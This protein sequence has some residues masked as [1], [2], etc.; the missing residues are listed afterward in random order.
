[1]AFQLFVD[2]TA[3]SRSA[4]S[5]IM[6]G[7]GS[8]SDAIKERR[9]EKK[10]ETKLFKANVTQAAAMG[11]GI[12]ED[13]AE[14][15]T[16]LQENENPDSIKGLLAGTIAS[17][18]Q[19]QEKARTEAILAQAEATRKDTAYKGRTENL[20]FKGL[21]NQN[22]QL[23][24]NLRFSDKQYEALNLSNEQKIIL[25]KTLAQKEQN[26]LELQGEDIQTKREQR[27]AMKQDYKQSQELHG[28]N[29]KKAKAFVDNVKANIRL[30][31]KTID[32]S[33]KKLGIL[34][35][36]AQSA[37]TNSQTALLNAKVA[38]REQKRKAN[39]ANIDPGQLSP[40]HLSDGTL[41]PGIYLTQDKKVLQLDDPA[42][43]NPNLKE[44]AALKGVLL[45]LEGDPN[46]GLDGIPDETYVDQDTSELIAENLHTVWWATAW[47]PWTKGE[48]KAGEWKANVRAKILELESRLGPSGTARKYDPVTGT[49][50]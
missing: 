50:K 3:G 47:M 29:K 2:P 24:K 16:Y 42:T 35:M 22:K 40:A 25:N 28:W 18:K 43:E 38:E 10:D 45:K 1:M 20:R 17:E 26:L 39:L 30:T 12:G 31:N 4:A 19:E 6:Q 33:D 37:L 41:I 8:I 14:R 36:N 49:F 15:E 21:E 5:S 9:K 13:I 11:L 32:Q 48:K 23:V 44:L 46:Q 34:N 27:K 7:A